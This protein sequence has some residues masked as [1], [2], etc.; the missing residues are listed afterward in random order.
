MVAGAAFP[1]GQTYIGITEDT[2]SPVESYTGIQHIALRRFHQ[3]VDSPIIGQF[4]TDTCAAGKLPI[5][6]FVPRKGGANKSYDQVVAGAIDAEL[7][8]AKTAL[9]SLNGNVICTFAPEPESGD[10]VQKWGGGISQHNLGPAYSKAWNYVAKI[11]KD[12]DSS[13]N[14]GNPNIRMAWCLTGGWMDILAAKNP[15]YYSWLSLYWPG[16]RFVDYVASDPYNWRNCPAHPAPDLTPEQLFAGLI[17]YAHQQDM[18]CGAFEYADLK[19]SRRPRFINALPSLFSNHN[20]LKFACYFNK[21][22]QA[23]GDCPFELQNEVAGVSGH[24]SLD[25][26]KTLMQSDAVATK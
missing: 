17:D 4:E 18:P 25:A 22:A 19:N 26:Y 9:K 1:T 13:G 12:V 11:L 21:D 6:S 15:T 7:N 3:D 5:I 24:P 14:I 20:R 16:A 23:S 2:R 10:E 8:A